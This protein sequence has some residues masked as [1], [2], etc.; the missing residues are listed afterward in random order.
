[1]MSGKDISRVREVCFFDEKKE[2][3][4]ETQKNVCMDYGIGS[5]DIHAG[6]YF[7]CVGIAGC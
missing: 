5:Y 4:Y 2:E 7:F 1:M 3:K 6:E